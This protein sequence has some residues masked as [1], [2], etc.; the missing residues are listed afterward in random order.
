M[1]NCKELARLLAADEF[2]D[3]R[4]MKR[5][6]VRFHLVMCRH[7]RRYA[8]QLEAIG[9]AARDVVGLRAQDDPARLERLEATILK[10]AFGKPPADSGRAQ[11]PKPNEP[12]DE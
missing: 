9:K 10:N 8:W 7:C 11:T 12:G 2:E 4:W 5:F 1:L 3:A 6:S